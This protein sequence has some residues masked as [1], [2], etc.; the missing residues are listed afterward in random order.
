M[1]LGQVSTWESWEPLLAPRHQ[2]C[3]A[4]WLPAGSHAWDDSVPVWMPSS[5]PDPAPDAWLPQDALL[6]PLRDPQ[7]KLLGV[8]AVDE[9]LSG[10]RPTDEELGVLMA[11]ADHAGLVLSLDHG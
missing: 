2:R 1:L 8:L 3:G 11:V 6:L 5:T 10:R 4:Y 7:A 9:P